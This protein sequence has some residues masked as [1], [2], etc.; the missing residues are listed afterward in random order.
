MKKWSIPVLIAIVVLLMPVSSAMVAAQDE[1][2]LSISKSADLT[3]AAVGETITYTYTVS[4][5]DNITIENISLVDDKIGT[6]DLG[7]QTSLGAGEN[8]TATATYTVAEA[9][10]PGPL[11]NTAT[12]SGTDPDGNPVTASAAASVDLTYT[13]SLH[14]TKTADPSPAAPNETVTYTYTITNNGNVT[15]DD[16]SLQDD[17]LGAIS[18]TD[19]TLAPGESATATATYAVTISDLPGPIVNT[20]TVNGTAPDGTLVSAT[21]DPISVSLYINKSILIKA[22]I[23]KL[24]GVPGKGIDKAP[25]LQKL[26]NPRSQAA[27][28]A[29][30][31]DKDEKKEQLRIRQMTEN[32]GVAKGQLKIEQK[33]RNQR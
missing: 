18:L 27:E 3:S 23:L 6:I 4:N 26:F 10:L 22:E 16:L 30:K 11:V 24:S 25:G 2:G 32:H 33:V 7:G 29:G 15:T 12:I 1:A 14:L 19:T 31:K 20:A 8:I 17:K 13:A 28:H 5:S 9:D 21:T